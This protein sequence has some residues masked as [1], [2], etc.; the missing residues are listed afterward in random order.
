MSIGYACLTLGVP[1]TELKT[2]RQINAT[3]ANLTSL[4]QHNLSSLEN[5]IDYNIEQNIMLFRISSDIIPFASSDFNTFKWSQ[6]FAVKLQA[7]GEKIKKSGM[8]VSMHPGQYTVL[9]SPNTD[10]VRRAVADL[11]YHA[12]L[13]DSLG[14]DSQHKIVLH[15]GGVY[16]DKQAATERFIISYQKLEPAVQRR[17]VL[18]NDDKSYN[19]GEVLAIAKLLQ[20]PVIFD[21]L[22][23]A[24]NSSEK[25]MSEEAW[26]AEAGKTW[27]TEDGRQKI[28]Y[29]QQHPLNRAG[30]HSTTIRFAEFLEFYQKVEGGNLDIM[31]EVKD[32]NLS[33]VKCINATSTETSHGKLLQEWTKYKYTVLE[34]APLKY[35]EIQQ[36]LSNKALR[37]V[38]KFYQLIEEALAEKINKENQLAV[39]LSIWEQLAKDA[40]EQE[41]KSFAKLL[42]SYQTGKKNIQAVKNALWKQADIYQARELLTSYYFVL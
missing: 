18:E 26:I 12:L 30:S 9:N 4:I 10:V 6:V 25:Q 19:I 42:E 20:V 27:Q 3:V 16:Q 38:K 21:N 39:V 28:H 22:H 8:R 41:K 13:L 23:H 29:S 14:V 32:K 24:I 34:A 7:I 31:L 11:N 40:S 1:N 37:P 35:H 17:L 2:C 5:I 36:L 15:I 33:A